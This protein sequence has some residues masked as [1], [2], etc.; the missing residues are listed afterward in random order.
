MANYN[1][2]DDWKAWMQTV[3]KENGVGAITGPLLQAVLGELSDTSEWMVSTSGSSADARALAAE[4]W[5]VGTQR[6]VPVTE[7]SPY[8]ENNSLYWSQQVM[9]TAGDLAAL[10]Q[11]AQTAIRGADDAAADAGRA[12]QSA[13]EAATLANEKSAEASAA[14]SL[15][16]EKSA[17]ASAAASLATEK[18]A[19]AEQQG[20]Y[21]RG[22]IDGAKG[23]FP[24]LNDRFNHVDET[25]MY[26]EETGV[27]ADPQLIDEYQRTLQQA[28]Q[29]ITDMLAATNM[30]KQSA[31]T[32]ELAARHA[33]TVADLTDAASR[34]ATEQAQ[35]AAAAAD[36]AEQATTD[37]TNA[38]G[39]ALSKARMA[40]TA[41]VTA[42]VRAEYAREQAVYATEQGDYAKSMGET[43]E[44]MGVF[45]EE[46]PLIS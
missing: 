37:A 7:G 20:N 43:L 18:A 38:A 16:N 24:S 29:C 8:Y 28:Y 12:A 9:A 40:E 25:A 41:A 19:Y 6:G 44:G 14:A 13:T 10:V 33:D 2:F 4:G 34:Q 17:E 35:R 26:F 46:A 1:S 36:S 32:A 21:A 31:T 23:D 15:A 11:Q 22:E 45:F 27:S 42:N 39:D 5:A 3:I 30:A